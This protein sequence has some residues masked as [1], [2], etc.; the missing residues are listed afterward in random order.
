MQNELEELEG[1]ISEYESA[2]T[3]LTSHMSD[4]S[5][6]GDAEKIQQ[7]T[8]AYTTIAEKLEAAISRWGEISDAIEKAE[9]EL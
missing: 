7:A 4:P 6:A 2:Q 5:T 3:A 9:A 8:S 1:Q